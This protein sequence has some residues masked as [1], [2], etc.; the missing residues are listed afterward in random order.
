[1]MHENHTPITDMQGHL[2]ELYLMADIDACSPAISKEHR[3][4]HAINR[5]VLANAWAEINLRTDPEIMG[6]SDMLTV[7]VEAMHLSYEQLKD[8]VRV[9]EQN[10]RQMHP[11]F[12][13]QANGITSASIIH[14]DLPDGGIEIHRSKSIQSQ[15]K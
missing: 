14:P 4:Q 10:N 11:V 7:P 1:M 9:M 12:I 5:D 2:A 3:A 6:P 13:I 15:I 8:M